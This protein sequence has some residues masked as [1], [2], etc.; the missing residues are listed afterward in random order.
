MEISLLHSTDVKIYVALLLVHIR[1]DGWVV[2]IPNHTFY[3]CIALN[4]VG[5][6][7]IS[8]KIY[9]ISTKKGVKYWIN[10]RD[11]H[12][13]HI[14]QYQIFAEQCT[15]RFN[16]KCTQ[17]EWIEDKAQAITIQNPHTLYLLTSFSSG[18]KVHFQLVTLYTM[19][20]TVH[21]LYICY[22]SL[23][24]CVIFMLEC[25]LLCGA[26]S[27]FFLHIFSLRVLFILCRCFLFSHTF[28]M[29]YYCCFIPFFSF[30]YICI[31]VCVRFG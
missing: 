6:Y 2:F 25:D 20:Y 3:V 12:N 31:C 17:L 1:S 5:V 4:R 26:L 29:H 8:I 14:T 15:F 19:P 24:F 28:F 23:C 21:T 27:R 7:F 16:N 10:A 22:I 30:L 13:V 18:S 11:R 9:Y